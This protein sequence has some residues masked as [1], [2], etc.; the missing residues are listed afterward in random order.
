[1]A[2]FLDVDGFAILQ[3]GRRDAFSDRRVSRDCG[4]ELIPALARYTGWAY[5]VDQFKELVKEAVEAGA[6]CLIVS[7]GYGLLRPEES[8]HDYD[9]KIEHTGSIWRDCLPRVLSTY[10]SHNGIQRVF[11]ACSRR[12]A[13]VIRGCAWPRGIE[14]WCLPTLPVGSRTGPETIGKAVVALIA[15]GMIAKQGWLRCS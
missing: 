6:H 1:M 11:V 4:S 3:R 5:R 8:I 7:A 12:Y 10:V 14:I 13:E 2:D 15:A 9:A